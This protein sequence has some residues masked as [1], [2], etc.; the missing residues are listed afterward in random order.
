MANL[1]PFLIYGLVLMGLGFLSVFTCGLGLLVLFPVVYITYY[2]SYR[3][4]LTEA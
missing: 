3:E 1:V 4:V 2:T